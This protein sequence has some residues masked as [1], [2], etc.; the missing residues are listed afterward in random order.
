M[1]YK[2]VGN[3]IPRR[4]LNVYVMK[5]ESTAMEMFRIARMLF[6]E[7]NIEGK[8]HMKIKISIRLKNQ[9]KRREFCVGNWIIK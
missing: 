5:I 9:L 4:R 1:P 7:T 2:G 3:Q 8:S 6:F